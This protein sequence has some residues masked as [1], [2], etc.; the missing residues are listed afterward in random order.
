MGQFNSGDRDI[1]DQEKC[2][3][4]LYFA[5]I[6][7]EY[8]FPKISGCGILGL[9][10]RRSAVVSGSAACLV[11]VPVAYADRYV[12]SPGSSLVQSRA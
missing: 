12:A 11:Q 2:D 6:H 8:F 9:N 4:F 10:R 7:K 1:L 3:L 5:L